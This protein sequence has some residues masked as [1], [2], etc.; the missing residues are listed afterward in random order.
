MLR[1]LIVYLLDILAQTDVRNEGK[2]FRLALALAFALQAGHAHM[3]R[4]RLSCIFFFVVCQ[5]R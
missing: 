1:L 4:V 2:G 5:G 3:F